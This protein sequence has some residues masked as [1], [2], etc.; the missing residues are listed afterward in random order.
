ML[1][2]NTCS[3]VPDKSSDKTEKFGFMCFIWRH[4]SEDAFDEAWMHNDGQEFKY[5]VSWWLK[6][7]TS[8]LHNARVTRQ[9]GGSGCPQLCNM[10]QRKQGFLVQRTL[11]SS[12]TFEY[13]ERPAYLQQMRLCDGSV[14]QYTSHLAEAFL[15]SSSDTFLP[16]A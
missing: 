16:F 2:N 7:T 1:R 6:A 5:M 15:T 10:D 8:R 12:E 14:A 3:R 9:T 4:V 11:W 13:I